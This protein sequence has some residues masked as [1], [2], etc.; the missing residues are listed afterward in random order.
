MSTTLSSLPCTRRTAVGLSAT[1]QGADGT[2]E[3]ARTAWAALLSSTWTSNPA[4][5]SFPVHEYDRPA[6]SGDA[7]AAVWGYSAELRSQ[8]AACGAVAYTFALPSASGQTV[9]A[10]F[11]TVTGDRYLALGVD[12]FVSL[13]ASADPPDLSSVASSTPAATL[14]ATASQAPTPPNNRHGVVA[15]LSLSDLGSAAAYLHIVLIPHLADGDPASLVRGAWIEGGA[16]LDPA[17]ISA[18]FSGSVSP[19]TVP[20]SYLVPIYGNGT[21]AD[22]SPLNRFFRADCSG[23]SSADVARIASAIVSGALPL[24]ARQMHGG[25][26]PY[27]HGGGQAA[28][29]E[30][31]FIVADF[32]MSQER[33][34]SYGYYESGKVGVAGSCLFYDAAPLRAGCS[35][36]IPADSSSSG[37][38]RAIA[39]EMDDVTALPDFADPLV[40]S[41]AASPCIG[42]I[43]FSGTAGASLRIARWPEAP[44]VAILLVALGSAQ[45]YE[46][47]SSTLP[48]SY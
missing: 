32:A 25:S 14:C 9:D 4:A 21:A 28:D 43:D 12:V 8:R 40:W 30:N 22:S 18:T 3:L 6:P 34:F 39:V 42:A 45:Q 2:T 23:S 33:L 41:G 29:A 16:M 35:V 13:S 37:T 46:P 27:I 11:A 7:F 38:F 5:P 26:Y 20:G 48:I 10:L 36:G 19:P 47:S 31:G 44:F 17:T 15:S 24:A 1:A